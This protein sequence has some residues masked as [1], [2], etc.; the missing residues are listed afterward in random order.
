[1]KKTEKKNN[2]STKL[3]RGT[4]KREEARWPCATTYTLEG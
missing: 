2:G 1:M 3:I 4:K